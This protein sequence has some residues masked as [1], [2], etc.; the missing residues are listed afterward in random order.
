MSAIVEGSAGQERAGRSAA[1]WPG[2]GDA[3]W[4]ADSP[5]PANRIQRPARL[6]ETVVAAVLGWVAG[7][8][9]PP[10]SVLPPEPELA[11]TFGVS[12]TVVREAVKELAAKGLVRVRQGKGTTVLD[13]EH[14]N[15][16]D[17]AVLRAV[18]AHR[19]GLTVL[20]DLVRVRIALES[21]LVAAATERI[22]PEQVA[23]LT[24]LM[25]EL[26]AARDVPVRYGELEIQ[27]HRRLVEISQ[28]VVGVTILSGIWRQLHLGDNR[29][30]DRV[31][32]STSLAEAHA[33]H[34]TILRE[35][36]RRDP[37]AA[38]EAVRAHITTSW[39]WVFH[40]LATHQAG[41]G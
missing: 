7:G 38:A 32:E 11:A 6:A 10:G 31:R 37:A 40:A 5:V 34:E 33:H 14:W 18:L 25:A 12:R 30:A 2:D 27:F 35:V 13:M 24:G 36:A 19:Q 39:S 22:T 3:P 23:E 15:L 41:R 26:T 21:E 9:S 4:P 17:D 8:G 20:A 16:L 1:L 29:W 28:N